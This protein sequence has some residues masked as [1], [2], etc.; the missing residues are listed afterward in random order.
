MKKKIY[1]ITIVLLFSILM[2]N[3]VYFIS[4]SFYTKTTNNP[5]MLIIY[6]DVNNITHYVSYDFEKKSTKEIFNHENVGFPTGSFSDDRAYLYYTYRTPELNYHLYEADIRSNNKVKNEINI[7]SLAV[8]LLEVDGNKIYMRALQLDNPNRR[9]FNV[10]V[11]DMQSKEID[12]WNKEETDISV[13]KF[14]YNPNTQKLYGVERS[15]KEIRSQLPDRA[16]NRIV[17]FDKNGNRIQELLE[18][19]MAIDSISVSKDGNK[20]LFSGNTT[21][22]TPYSTIYMADFKTSTVTPILEGNNQSI[23][24]WPVFSPDEKGFYYLAITPDSKQMTGE[25]GETA[26]TR[27]V[28]YYDFTTKTNSKIFMKD[29]G[30]VRYFIIHN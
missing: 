9:N 24:K 21:T 15:E 22:T 6:T 29:D 5:T 14:D 30:T 7:P 10:V 26:W 28:Y 13:Y 3:I 8:D 27:G 1:T 20:G 17:E 23:I 4:N 25:S 2:M 16:P 12:I 19:N 18:M 11:Y